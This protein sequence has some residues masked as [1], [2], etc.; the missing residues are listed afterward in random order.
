MPLSIIKA[1]VSL[2][3]AQIKAL[4]TTPIQLVVAPGASKRIEV[5]A[6]SVYLDTA[7]GAYTNINTDLAVLQVRYDNS[8]W[9]ANTLFNDSSNAAGDGITPTTALSS[10]LGVAAI[11]LWRPIPPDYM[12]SFNA[13]QGFLMYPTL[14]ANSTNKKIEIFL[15]NSGSGNL[16]GGNASNLMKARVTYQVVDVP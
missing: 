10:F 5:M 13:G 7:A 2:T 3:D 4:S 6:V 11:Q 1:E 8:N 12:D 16:T 14:V 9:V 15:D